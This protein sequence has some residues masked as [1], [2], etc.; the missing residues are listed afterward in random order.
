LYHLK[1]LS[2]VAITEQQFALIIGRLRMYNHLPKKLQAQIPSLQMGDSQIATVVKD[3]YKDASF[4]RN[5]EGDINLWRLYNLLTNAN[6]SSYIDN[7]IDRSVNAYEFVEKIR[8]A[9]EDKQENWYLS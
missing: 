6:K 1:Q 3:Y 7:F 9:V 4:C 8:Y 5:E 2:K